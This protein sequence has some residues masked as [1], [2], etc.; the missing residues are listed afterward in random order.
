MESKD[1]RERPRAL[2]FLCTGN[3]C[4]SQI[5]EGF[6]RRILPRD[7]EVYSAGIAP[8]GVNPW[9]IRIMEEDGIDIR[10]Q[11][12]KGLS[13]VPVERIDTVITLCGHAEAYCPSFPGPVTRHHWPIDDPVG[14]RGTEEQI[15]KAFRKAR[16]EIKA[17]ID[18]YCRRLA[19][20]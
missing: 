6:A 12:S 4:R 7:I 18:D 16:D 9:T 19:T 10:D 13:G 17:R 5:A 1:G 3:S 14:T 20:S 11:K 2:L 8:A 15:L